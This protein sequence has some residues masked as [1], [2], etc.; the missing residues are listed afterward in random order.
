VFVSHDQ[1][2]L[3]RFDRLLNMQGFRPN[4]IAA[5]TKNGVH[6]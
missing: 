6:V 5:S 2:L 4:S 1:Q 3:P